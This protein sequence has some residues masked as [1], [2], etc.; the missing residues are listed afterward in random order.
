MV[1]ATVAA[2]ISTICAGALRHYDA[3]TAAPATAPTGS[4]GNALDET[5]QATAGPGTARGGGGDC[6]GRSPNDARACVGLE[7]DDGCGGR[8]GGGG[9]GGGGG[10][11]GG[12]GGGHGHGGIGDI[13]G[14]GGG[15]RGGGGGDGACTAP[16][17]LAPMNR[18][19]SS[20]TAGGQGQS[21]RRQPGNAEKR[22]DEE[23]VEEDG[24][25]HWWTDDEDIGKEN[26]PTEAMESDPRGPGGGWMRRRRR[27][28]PFLR[29]LVRS[30]VGRCSS[31]N[32]GL[33][34]TVFIYY[35]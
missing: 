22:E 30:Q 33:A 4:L 23:E 1:Q 21:G 34:G 18:E 20:D 6:T 13:G 24:D 3:I 12:C 29:L 16:M 7:N 28:M 11:G 5:F 25:E 10:D 8:G 32:H 9:V 17:G 14:G 27:V 15:G 2:H 26:E 19:S 31:A 35:P